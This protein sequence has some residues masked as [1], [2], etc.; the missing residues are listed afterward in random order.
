M[1]LSSQDP[2]APPAI[3]P[4]YFAN[5]AD[6]DLAV[7]MVE[8]ALK[9]Y[10]SEPMSEAV[11]APVTPSAET[12]AQGRKG[13]EEFVRNYCRPVYHPVGTAAMLA[14][15]DGGVVDAK[16]RVYGTSNLRV[17]SSLPYSSGYIF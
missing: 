6:L 14:R 7:H 9:L 8:A 17:V 10:R 15:A 4:N 1:H 12:L 2:L 11:K 5:E 16:L 13:L 3:D